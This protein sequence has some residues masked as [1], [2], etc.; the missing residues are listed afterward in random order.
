MVADGATTLVVFEV[1]F[2][3]AAAGREVLLRLG[4]AWSVRAWPAGVRPGSSPAAAVA[5]AAAVLSDT[6]AVI[7]RAGARRVAARRGPVLV[8]VLVPVPVPVVGPVVAPSCA[9]AVSVVGF[10]CAAARFR[11]E[12]ARVGDDAVFRVRDVPA[13]VDGP[14]RAFVVLPAALDFR[15]AAGVGEGPSELVMS[16]MLSLSWSR[17]RCPIPA[18][19]PDR[20]GCQF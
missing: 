14:V 15:V 20:C 8:P 17:A 6:A 1:V 19:R 2:C 18:M 12:G 7:F 16:A 5:V 3:R 10:C 9:A 11:V 4:A 13:A